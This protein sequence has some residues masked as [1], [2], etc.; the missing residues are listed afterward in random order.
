MRIGEPRRIG[1][2]SRAWGAPRI[3]EVDRTLSRVRVD[4]FNVGAIV[5]EGDY[6]AWMDGTARRLHIFGAG[7]ADSLGKV[8]LD[9]EPAPP[10]SSTNIPAAL[11]MHKASAEFIVVS[12]EASYSA[13]IVHE[14]KL[15]AI[16]VLR[17]S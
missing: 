8:W 17:R 6:G 15:Q 16:Q 7:V 14:G 12:S 5:S 2:Q 9:C 13:P 3:V 4:G 1:C 10:T 11:E